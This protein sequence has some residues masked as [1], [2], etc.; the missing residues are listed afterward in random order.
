VRSGKPR[1]IIRKEGDAMYV[2]L[3]KFDI[4]PEKVEEGIEIY[5]KSVVPAVKSQKGFIAI[6]LLTDRPT[7]KGYS[8]SFWKTE[9]DALAN[10][11]NRFYQE[12]LVKFIEFYQSQPFREGYEV[13]VKG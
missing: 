6:Y 7:G 4:K 8:I 11:R 10:E 13:M 12:Q 2:R 9:Q 3:T 1:K 5:R